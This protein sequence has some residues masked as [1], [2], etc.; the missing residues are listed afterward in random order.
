[1][2]LQDNPFYIL[3]IPCTAGRRDI[4]SA[5]EE[6]SFLL[7]P[8]VCSA[9]QNELIN[10]SKRL[11]AELGWFIELEKEK[12]DSIHEK[13]ESGE[14]IQTDGLNP[15]SKLNAT[16]YNY[17]ISSEFDVFE[18]GYAI[19][20]IDEQYSNL[21]ANGICEILNNSR[22]SAKLST[23]TEKEISVEINNKRDD[24]RQII[25]ERLSEI[26]Q[27]SY[28]ELITMLAEKCIA[29]DDYEDGII[30][31]DV[32]DQYEVRMQA[33]IEESTDRIETHITHIQQLANDKA[34]SENVNT[35]IRQVQNWDK[36]AQPLQLKSQASGMSHEISERLGR[37]LHDL[38]LYLHNEKGKTNEALTLV[39][40][41]KDV[42]AELGDLSD[43]FDSD[44][45]ALNDLLQGEKDAKEV[46]AE[47]DAV[48][49]LAESLKSF[50]TSSS[51]DAFISRV[52]NI[53][54]K[55]KSLPL[56]SETRT[57]AREN[58]CY[59]AR[60]AAIELH[61][62][63]HQ[64]AY[65]LTI[66]KALSSEFGD[67]S[68]LKSKLL[69]D[70]TTL[71]QQLLLSNRPLYSG[72]T[73]R[74]SSSSSNMGCLISIGVIVLIVII[75]SVISS[76][77]SSSSKSSTNTSKPSSSYSQ[78]VGGNSG[79]YNRGNKS[80]TT[81]PKSTTSNQSE[82]DKLKK[83]IDE[84][85]S[86]LESLSDDIDDY[87]SQLEDLNDDIEYYKS[88]YYATGND[89][90]YNSYYSAVDEYNDI[91]E[92]YSDVRDEY[93][94]LYSKYTSAINGYNQKIGY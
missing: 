94:S 2:K 69:Q 72:N 83:E 17:S 75:I 70:T 22:T 59:M 88:Q 5:A 51:V 42:F 65:A 45:E 48:S 8:D 57:K 68:S 4:I 39:N 15:L 50:A 41:M 29:D 36:L 7:D 16:L 55:L 10:S 67:I 19:L 63:K 34:I 54:T 80:S 86:K 49:I 91:Y 20:D 89:Y 33:Q 87:E 14:E 32:I 35:L 84:M 56:D 58:L 62:T 64:T 1:M 38:A 37:S 52:K 60:E 18:L 27:D 82:L 12:L 30:L 9:A 73:T 74:S 92:D 71:N 81:T 11:T 26:D 79:S 53:D 28:V 93:N 13:I 3:N 31:A 25:S 78:N 90:Y 76:I 46:L 77:G 85:E 6:L 23:L 21:D 40:A 43:T 24:I 61:N 66:S 44:S 47:M